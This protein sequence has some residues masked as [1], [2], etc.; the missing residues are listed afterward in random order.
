MKHEQKRKIT[1]AFI[2]CGFST[3]TILYHFEKQL[4]ENTPYQLHILLFEKRKSFGDGV[5]YQT[6]LPHLRLNTLLFKSNLSADDNKHFETWLIAKKKRKK[7]FEERSVFGTYLIENFK[8][9]TKRLENKGVII[10]RIRG[11]VYDIKPYKNGF[12]I[13][14]LGNQQSWHTNYLMLTMGV[15]MHENIYKLS[16]KRYI[17]DIYYAPHSLKDI[18]K[19]DKVLV[20]GTS[21]SGQDL[22]NYFY[23]N[24]HR[25]TIYIYSQ[26]TTI[27][28][29]F[30]FKFHKPSLKLLQ[31][32]F[33]PLITLKHISLAIIAQYCKEKIFQLVKT[34]KK[35]ALW[36]KG[37]SIK[38]SLISKEIQ[39][40]TMDI[41]FLGIA[42]NVADIE[43]LWG[44][45]SHADKRAFYKLYYM[46]FKKII[47]HT[48][49]YTLKKILCLLER[50]QLVPLKS[51]QISIEETATGSFIVNCQ[52]QKLSV[53]WVINA[54]GPTP[55]I[56]VQPLYKS[57]LNQKLITKNPLKGIAI[58]PKTFQCL[59]SNKKNQG[60]IYA[61]SPCILGSV[62]L[63]YSI[64]Y[65]AKAGKNL[66]THFINTLTRNSSI[67]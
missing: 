39:A 8:K 15:N 66:S 22:I 2:G 13:D 34:N 42:L 29:M 9:T 48:H 27:A 31:N 52:K 67:G 24:K 40:K 20:L 4:Q 45:L 35:F 32:F 3:T 47:I 11:S 1:I 46:Q 55:D 53:D 60:K 5:S 21:A 65:L 26:T 23:S 38:Q 51:K 56:S 43:Y 14:V 36:T 28:H 57:L 54:T 12:R 41:I 33:K 61:L 7:L 25:A 62:L 10:E 37:I 58:D 49:R 50:K 6:E 17:N 63:P 18:Q 19:N 64:T 30:N 59:T 44:R 16:S